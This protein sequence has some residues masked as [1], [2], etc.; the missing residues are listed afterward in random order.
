MIEKINL[1]KSKNVVNGLTWL[2]IMKFA[3]LENYFGLCVIAK[4][5]KDINLWP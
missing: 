3:S 5:E 4:H 1:K 2:L